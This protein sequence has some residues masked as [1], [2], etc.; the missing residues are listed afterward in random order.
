[1]TNKMLS[2]NVVEEDAAV[3][4][5][6]FFRCRRLLHFIA[7]RVLGDSDREDDAI[8]NCWLCACRNRPRFESEGALRRWL[9]RVLIN[10]ALAIRRKNEEA[11][12]QRPSV[13][14]I[15]SPG[16]AWDHIGN[17]EHSTPIK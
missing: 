3:F 17:A 12:E 7:T 1:M 13:E 6:R 10:E 9:L 14:W 2:T 8:E 15:P 4:Q 16:I 5:V 11:I